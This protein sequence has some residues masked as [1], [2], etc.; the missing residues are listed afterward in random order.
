M[1]GGSGKDVFVYSSGRDEISDFN[2]RD[3]I[4]SLD[5]SL[6]IDSFS[7]L[8]GKAKV[9]DDGDDVLFTFAN[10]NTL[11]LEDVD[12][13]SLKAEHFGLKPDTE[14]V[15]TPKDDTLIGA[16]GDDTLKGGGGNDKIYGHGGN[17]E[18]EGNSGN[19]ALYGGGGHDDLEGGSGND[20]LDG[21]S[22]RNELK[23]GSGSDTFVFSAGRTEIE[24]FRAGSDKV[25]LSKLLGVSNFSDM[26][27]LATTSNGGE[28]IRIDL[29]GSTL[30]FED[31]TIRELKSSDFFFV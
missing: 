14:T 9:V 27:K 26:M 25:E 15:P 6:G 24:D 19:D 11:T 16:A 21:G 31:T 22:G 13:R 18:L 3:D 12:V 5:K 2:V 17:D 4:I 1:E 8:L 23:G 10:G 29:G 30:I 28:D 20:R 7:E